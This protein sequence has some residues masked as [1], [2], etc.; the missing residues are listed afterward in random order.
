MTTTPNHEPLSLERAEDVLAYIPHALGF[1]PEKS[2]VL[3]LLVERRLEATLRVDLPARSAERTDYQ[4]WI[5]QV[6]EL[7]SRLPG[8]SATVGV[9]YPQSTAGAAGCLPWS[10][11]ISCLAEELSDRDIP[12]HQAWCYDGGQVWDYSCENPQHGCLTVAHPE[13]SPTS[14]RLVV[15]GSAPLTEP[16]DGR[17]VHEWPNATQIRELAKTLDG[18]YLDSLDAWAMILDAQPFDAERILRNE[19]LIPARLISGLSIRMVRDILPYLAGAGTIA[20]VNAV[21]LIQA[22]RRGQPVQISGMTDFLLGRGTLTPQW[23]RVEQLWFIC[24]DLL[25]VAQGEERAALLCLLAWIEWA[26]GRGSMSMA[27]LRSAL[28]EEPGYRLAQ[29]LEQLLQRGIMPQ[30]ATDPERAWRASFE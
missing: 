10:E 26:K 16:W 19:P 18:D 5:A 28:K 29:L 8:L 22:H 9:V 2:V 13:L 3:L 27:L 21:S 20:A 17:D 4:V 11:L 30:W 15:A 14:L 12:L 25:G 6:C 7:L 24:R 1:H 23:E